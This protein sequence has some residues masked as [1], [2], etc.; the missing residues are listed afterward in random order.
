MK[1]QEITYLKQILGLQHGKKYDVKSLSTVT[2]R[3]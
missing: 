1:N 3:S 2:S